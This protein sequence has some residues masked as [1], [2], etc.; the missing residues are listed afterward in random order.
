GGGGLRRVGG[1]LGLIEP[2]SQLAQLSAGEARERVVLVGH[3]S[4]SGLVD[5]VTSGDGAGVAVGSGT[6]ASDGESL[7][8]DASTSSGELPTVTV[9][10]PFSGSTTSTDPV[11]DVTV[12]G[13]LAL[14]VASRSPSNDQTAVRV[15]SPDPNTALRTLSPASARPAVSRPSIAL[16][17]RACAKAAGFGGCAATPS[18]LRS[19]MPKLPSWLLPSVLSSMRSYQKYF[20]AP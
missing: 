11:S 7:E 16:M 12:T 8:A 5:T 13:P 4:S 6:S 14:R 2:G 17:S 15:S 19:Y 9:T 10:D 1:L 20:S 3:L 18:R